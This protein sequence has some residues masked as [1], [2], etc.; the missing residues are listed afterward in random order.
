MARSRETIQRYIA[1][2]N[3]YHAGFNLAG[4][5]EWTGHKVTHRQLGSALDWEREQI[6]IR[7]E[8]ESLYD[9]LLATR[10]LRSQANR[11]L[12]EQWQSVTAKVRRF[13]I[14]EVQELIDA[15]LGYSDRIR[16]LARAVDAV[17][18]HEGLANLPAGIFSADLEPDRGDG[19]A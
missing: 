16:E 14:K 11:I 6:V 7:S 2:C 10:R 5:C 19:A 1:I 3:A 18:G 13:A 15:E 9:A 17:E 12:Q 8:I 4:I